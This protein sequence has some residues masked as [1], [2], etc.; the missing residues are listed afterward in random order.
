[1]PR[2]PLPV[3][4]WGE[5][6]RYPIQRK[7]GKTLYL[8]SHGRKY[9]ARHD[10]EF[11]TPI[12]PDGWIA[13]ARF[14][15]RDGVTRLIEAWGATAGQAQTKLVSTLVERQEQT[16]GE[17]T[18]D[19]RLK[20]VGDQWLR[21][22][23]EDSKKLAPR[24][25]ARYR[26]VWE[27]Y[28]RPGVGNLLMRECSIRSM[29]RFLQQ[30]ARDT[31]VATAKLCKSV[32]S[33]IMKYAATDGCIDTNPIMGV[34]DFSGHEKKPGPVQVLT[35]EQLRALRAALR[36]DMK[37]RAVDLDVMADLM[38]A[39]GCRIGEALALRWDE[40]VDLESGVL[41]INGTVVRADG[42]LI[43]QDFT[44]GKK[45]TLVKLP[46]WILPRLEAHRDAV[47]WGGPL[48]LVFPSANSTLRDVDNV[49]AQWRAFRRRHPDLPEFTPRAFRKA[50]ATAI[51]RGA[52][53]RL[54]S[55]QLGHADDLVTRRHYIEEETVVVD[56]TLFVESF[57]F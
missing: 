41:S 33:N 11:T 23:I 25:Q 34:Q 49:E 48:N 15:D 47:T 38:L 17:F 4:S 26:E 46:G 19:T 7:N 55:Q 1:M 44:K 37:A 10:T 2:K 32:L 39:S 16:G 22:T 56:A 27:S 51:D 45:T 9:F 30:T 57:E 5:V 12:K 14:R 36:D 24:T 13:R 21:T 29:D 8:V 3:G 50:V 52:G 18:P 40:D 6:L 31:G 53:S 54:A 28:I 42:K 20:F 43:R 35:T